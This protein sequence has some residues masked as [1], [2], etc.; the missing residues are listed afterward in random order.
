[1][2]KIAPTYDEFIVIYPEFTSIAESVVEN[3]LTLASRMIDV[4]AWGDFYSDAIGLDTAHSLAIKAMGGNKPTGGLQ[5]AVGAISGV[6]AAGVSTSFATV[7]PDAKHKSDIW[8]MKTAYGLE[9]LS[10]RDRV[11]PLGVMAS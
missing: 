1:M 7:T 10:L 8:Y 3:A 9:F 11:I 5:G 2:A 4:G 6:S